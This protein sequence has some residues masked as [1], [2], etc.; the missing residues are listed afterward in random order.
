M[1]SKIYDYLTE[2]MLFDD[3][4]IRD[5]F[6]NV[7]EHEL[8]TELRHYREFCL[9]N[10]PALEQEVLGNDSNLKLFSGVEGAK[11]RSPKTER[12]LCRAVCD[13]RSALRHD[14]R[15]WRAQTRHE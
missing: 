12:V 15:E 7:E 13:A 5:E 6:K 8:K 10:M 11:A 3:S 1:G 4:L 2:S 14:I 9:T